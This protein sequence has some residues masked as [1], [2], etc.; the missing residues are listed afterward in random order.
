MLSLH[1]ST[2]VVCSVSVGVDVCV[3]VFVGQEKVK[4]LRQM[5]A[6]EELCVSFISLADIQ[7]V[8]STT[9]VYICKNQCDVKQNNIFGK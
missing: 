7:Y 5:T 1:C 2:G 9:Y 8:C 4:C 6:I 3:I